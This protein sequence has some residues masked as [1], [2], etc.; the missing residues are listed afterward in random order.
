MGS[1]EDNTMA[2][3]DRSSS[4]EDQGEAALIAAAA[5]ILVSESRGIPAD[6]VTALFAYAVPEDLM[7]YGA[8]E[9]AELAADAWAHLAVRKPGTPNIR[10]AASDTSGVLSHAPPNVPLSAPPK[11]VSVLEIVNDDMPFLVDSVMSELNQRGIDI[12]LVLHPIFTVERDRDGRLIAFKG[13]QPPGAGAQRESFIHIHTERI[14][15][16]A[17]RAEAVEALAKVLGDVR[18]AVAD[19]RPMLARIG[20]VIATLKDHPPPLPAIEIAEAIQFLEWLEADNFTFLGMRNYRFTA[21]ETTL[22][23]EFE[24]GLGVLRSRER[25]VLQVWNQPLVITPA[26]RALLDSPTLLIVTKSSVRSRV[27]RRVYMDYIGV[28]RFAADGKLIGEFRIVGLFTSTAYTRSTRSI[29][30]LRRKVDAVVRRA[31]FNPDGHSGKALVNVLETY[32]RD[33]LFQVDED[34]LY[35]FTLAILQL[36]ERPRVRVLPRRDRFDRFVSILLYVPRD[37]Y[38]SG[39]RQE[40]GRYLAE[41]YKGRV[42]AF[43]PFFTEGP[44]VRTHFIIGLP[45]GEHPNPDRGTLERAVEA[46][47]RTWIDTVGDEL[48]RVYDPARARALLERYRNA[49]SEGYREVYSPA[50]ALADIRVIEGLSPSRPLGVDFHRRAGDQADA[51]GLKIWSYDRPIPLSERVPVLENMGFKVV[52]ERTYQIARAPVTDGATKDV[53]FH[54][55]LLQ[56]ADGRAVDLDRLKQRLE[57]CFLV[58]MGGTAEN[59]GFNAL[60]LA[61][62]LMWRDV[63]LIRAIS[64]FLRQI[65]IPYSQ[66]YL[67]TT[68]VKHAAITLEIVRLFHGR[69]N[70]HH[71]EAPR[72]AEFEA[73]VAGAIEEALRKV[74]SLD[75]D[76][77]LRHFVNAVQAAIRTNFYQVDAAGQPKQLIA[78]KFSSRKL[79]GLP[80]PKPLYEIFVYSPRVE[81][82]HLRFGKVARGGIR[83]SDRPQDFRTEVLGLVKAQQVK[84]AVIVPVGAKGGY[85][86]KWL[87]GIVAGGGTR[88]AIQAEG[89]AAYRLF[90]STLLDITDNLDPKGKDG[91]AVIPP[92]NVVRHDDDDPYLVVAADKGTA[93]FSDLA[94]SIAQEHGYWLDDAFA[95]GG[96]A[97]YDHKKIGI[98]ARGA[99]ESVKRHFREMDIDL[100][101][102]PFTAV[103]VGDMSGDVF[104]NGMLREKTTK[105]VAAFD[106]RDIFIDP[107]PDPQ[108]AFAERARL[109]ALPRSS[110][111]DYDKSLISS[112]GG[113]FSR[114][115]KEITLSGEAQWVLG[116]NKAK[117]TPQEVIKAILAAPV[118]LLFFGGIGTYVRA[119]SET[120]DAVGDRTNDPVRVTGAEL[121]AKVIGEGANLGMTQRGRVEAALR[122]IRLNTDAIDNSAGVNTSDVE[123][124][125][126]IALAIPM[127]DG[128]LTRAARNALLT[129]MTEDVAALVLRNNYLQTLALSLAQRR[130]LEDLGFEQ[131]LMQ[132][133][134]SAGELDRAVEFLPDDMELA[135]RRRRSVALTRPELS[136]LLAYAKL[137]LNHELLQSNVPDD[138]YLGRELG[139]YFPKAVADKFPDALEHH[140]LRREIIAT[141]LAN[142]MINR[143]GPSLLVRIADQTGASPASIAAA[144]AAVRDSYGMTALNGEIDVL[145][146]R[147]SGKLQLELY[148]AV[149]DL[150]L[151]RLVWFLRNVDL[152]HGLATIVAHY[153][154]GIAAVEA[155]LGAALPEAATSARQARAAELTKDGV[156]EALARRIATLPALAHAPDIVMV[157]DRTGQNI[158]AVTATYFATEAFFRLDRI[159]SAARGIVISDYFDRLALDRA[160]DSIGDAERRLTAAM[161]GN[162]IAGAPAVE[163]WIAP[164]KAEVDRIRMS[165][166]EIANSGL[167]LSK[168]SVAASLLGD[169]VKQ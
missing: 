22:E 68:L 62:G 160:L 11:T 119:A 165:V 24:T 81:A 129:E 149:Q 137:S 123:V 2:V 78:V 95:S 145:D 19:W 59:D 73:E 12:S 153:C 115:L 30:Y 16:D 40:I 121:R 74:E 169:L 66:D 20:E 48:A 136:V 26:I 8:R 114:S 75:E 130:G 10:F 39:V 64:R 58:V 143:G 69:F 63:A 60:V 89:T 35:Q 88:E 37:R 148:Q 27:H 36:D 146:N 33:E 85:V 113:V 139:R 155:A 133:L 3:I 108:R 125:L 65:R 61:T 126:K 159:A 80:L 34:T 154:E 18:L 42:S 117:A 9:L 128:R 57:A 23:P 52:D 32:P 7:H 44:L 77:I 164:R 107:T 92:A 38:D 105:L 102:T 134:E 28:K 167:T 46:I 14:D 50:T 109:F 5:K 152:T 45:E 166:H 111:Q 84:N 150:L 4:D 70:P 53:W 124:N 86:P 31:G 116:F 67:W 156:P 101:T 47:V 151:D 141:Q 87:P 94:N 72:R 82:V 15:D 99:W 118:D 91:A 163:A 43:H 138:P 140:R 103:G 79:D 51:V 132:T 56:R 110:W 161:A 127:R 41:A 168:L 120:D 142:S 144:F 1:A 112:G 158:A 97:G 6:F 162:G 157:A 135:E 106:H 25:G 147:I 76:R 83:W 21:G 49:F 93:T 71:Q 90:I 104:G 96:S 54:D 13:A 17:R 122:G 29:P 131:R 55:M 100:A 98:T